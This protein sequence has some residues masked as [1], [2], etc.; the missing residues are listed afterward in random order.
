MAGSYFIKRGEKVI[1]PLSPDAL[2]DRISGGKIRETD[3]VAKASTGPWKAILDVPA[4]ANLFESELD[5]D[6]FDAYGDDAYGLPLPKQNKKKTPEVTKQRTKKGADKQGLSGGVI[7]LL[8]VGPVL[9]LGAGLVVHFQSNLTGA[10]ELLQREPEKENALAK[11]EQEKKQDFGGSVRRQKKQGFAN[12]AA[13]EPT[14]TLKGHS[15]WVT[16]VNFSPDGK[17]IV[18]GSNDKTVKVWDAD[19]GQESLT[20]KGYRGPANLTVVF[21]SVAFSPDGKQI[22]TSSGDMTVKVWDADTGQETLILKGHTNAV[23]SVAYSPD[24]K[25]IVSGSD[26][27]T[28]KVWDAET[29]QETLTLKGHT[30]SVQSV[31]F[32]PDGKQ[33]VSGSFDE[34]VKVWDLSSLD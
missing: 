21:S 16:S 23:F 17:W 18:S 25:R 7:A 28:V 22:A 27:M 8:C 33:I 29:G 4:L 1:G 32:S 13:V 6:S 9:V 19:T 15:D 10:N 2:K 34:T 3:Q 11:R 30:D 31:A 12:A 5:D 24:G 20:L 26:D 14:V